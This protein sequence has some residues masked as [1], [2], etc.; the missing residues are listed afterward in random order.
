MFRRLVRAAFDYPSSQYF[1]S[2]CVQALVRLNM[3][4]TVVSVIISG[5]LQTYLHE[6]QDFH[7]VDKTVL[8]ACG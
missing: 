7:Q 1:C 2:R 5:L 8:F 6:G 4:E 3:L